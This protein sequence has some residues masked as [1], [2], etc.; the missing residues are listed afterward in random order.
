MVY[1]EFLK[2]LFIMVWFISL[3]AFIVYWRK[4]VGAKKA[5]GENY[6]NDENY[7]NISKMKRLIGIVCLVSFL[8]GAA[9][10]ESPEAKAEREIKEQQRQ[11]EQSAKAEQKAA[12]KAA[13]E[14]QKAEEKAAKEAE[15]QA[16]EQEKAAAEA[17]K[18]A[19]ADIDIL[20]N[21][22]QNNAAAANKNYKGKFVKIVGGVLDHIESDG[23]YISI[24]NGDMTL[25]HVQCFPKNKEVK[26]QM[27]NLSNGQTVT[28]YGKI[29][30]VGGIIGYSL[31]MDKVE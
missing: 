30:R 6:A 12:E 3:I 25:V 7:N 26:E 29:T 9:I 19:E 24:S 21:D 14:Q 2:N 31:D 4:K 23:D 1:V 17:N 16:K 18:Y 27:L 10:P 5:A 15:K 28:V 20:I 22:V 13:K 8:I 11:I